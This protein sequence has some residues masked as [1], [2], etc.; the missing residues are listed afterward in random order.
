M[1][2]HFRMRFVICVTVIG[3][4]IG[5]GYWCSWNAEIFSELDLDGD[6]QLSL[7]EIIL[8]MQN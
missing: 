4:A 5:I 1:V 6:E 8:G 3:L 2:E 7:E